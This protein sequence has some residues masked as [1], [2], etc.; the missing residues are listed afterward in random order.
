[1]VSFMDGK[2]FAH[3]NESG[4]KGSLQTDLSQV[5]DDVNEGVIESKVYT[6]KNHK[7]MRLQK[8]N[9]LLPTF[10]LSINKL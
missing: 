7:I 1:M 4:R 3:V 2:G 6:N 10:G 9:R 8:I 5:K